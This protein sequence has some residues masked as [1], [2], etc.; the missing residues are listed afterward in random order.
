M[1]SAFKASRLCPELV[2]GEVVLDT[3]EQRIAALVLGPTC[4]YPAVEVFATIPFW[5]C[6]FPTPALVSGPKLPVM[7]PVYPAL[8]RRNSWSAETSVPFEFNE[9]IL[10]ISTQA[11]AKEKKG[12]NSA[13]MPARSMRFTSL[14]YRKAGRLSGGVSPGA[15]AA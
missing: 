7:A 2:E 14:L 12:A 15:S 3:A 5:S 9:S 8:S 13:K 4:P 6:Q 1:T 11:A 10:E